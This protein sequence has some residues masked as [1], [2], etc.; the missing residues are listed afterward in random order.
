MQ[1]TAVAEKPVSIDPL[2]DN[3]FLTPDG[4]V[5]FSASC[6]EGNNWSLAPLQKSEDVKKNP[7]LAARINVALHG[8]GARIAFAPN[9]TKF[10]G[11]VI[12]PMQLIYGLNLG[13]VTLRRHRDHPADATFLR[14][15]GNAGIFSAGG[16][17]V[18]VIAYK[19]TLMFGHA[20]RESLVDRDRVLTEGLVESRPK[21]LIDNMIDALEVKPGEEGEVYAWPLYFIKPE[22]FSHRFDDPNPEHVPYNK[23]AARYLPKMYPEFGMVNDEGINIDLPGIAKNQLMDRGVPEENINLEHAYLS[24]ELPTT[25]RGGGRYLVAIVRH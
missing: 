21:D 3:E 2:V 18:V 17:G 4:R 6:F 24:D 8:L 1:G 11:L 12:P 13:E 10:N 22:H 9:P 5:A 16:C 25:R 7:E 15:P 23:A 19:D 20:G 14:Y